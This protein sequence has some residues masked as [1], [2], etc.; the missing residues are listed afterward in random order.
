M[1]ECFKHSSG[2]TGELAVG[3]MI[4]R[5]LVLTLNQGLSNM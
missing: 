5:W 4:P 1:L 3:L 2:M